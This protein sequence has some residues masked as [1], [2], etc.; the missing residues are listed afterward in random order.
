MS[1]FC[2]HRVLRVNGFSLGNLSFI[3]L[4]CRVPV[5]EPRRTFFLLYGSKLTG[6]ENTKT[7][8][9]QRL[10]FMHDL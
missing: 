4:I 7:P 5:A 3:H 10:N 2:M 1:F 6:L 8:L 9:N